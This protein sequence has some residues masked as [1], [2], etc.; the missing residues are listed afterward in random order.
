MRAQWKE[1]NSRKQGTRWLRSQKDVPHIPH[2]SLSIVRE[3]FCPVSNLEHLGLCLKFCLVSR[4]WEAAVV[5]TA[6][7]IL[8]AL[9]LGGHT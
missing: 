6:V 7:G 1:A 3:L 8:A 4:V 5:R 2:P 9:E